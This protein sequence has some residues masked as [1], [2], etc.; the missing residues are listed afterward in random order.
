MADIKVLYINSDGKRNE[1]SESAD[2]VKFASYKTA[3]YELTDSKLGNLVDGSDA[4]DEH[5]HDA[6]YYRENEHVSTSAGAGD[7]GKPVVLDAGG[8][9]DESLIDVSALTALIDHGGLLGLGD[10]DHTIYTKADG[11]RDFSGIVSYSSHP[12]FTLDTQIVDKKYVDDILVSSE[13]FY[14]SALDYILDN[15]LAPPTEVAGD[16]YVLSH[17]GGAP[18][19]NWDGASAGDIVEFNGSVWVATTPSTGTRIGVDDEANVA[20]YLY[21]GSSWSPK[22]EE[23]TTASTG[24]TKVGFDIRI[25][26]SAAGDGLGFAA[27]VLNVN[28]DNSSVEINADTLRVKA[29][30]INDT[31]IDFGTGVNQV[32]AGDIPLVDAGG[33]FATDDVEFALQKLASDI[34]SPGIFYTVGVGGV[35]KGDALYISSNDTVSK[36]STLTADEEVVG[37]ALTTEAASGTVK[38]LAN[39]TIVT[40]VLTGAVAGTEY[41]WNGTTFV[42]TLTGF[43]GNQNIWKVGVA[44]NATDLHVQIEHIT[45]KNA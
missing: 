37:L 13:W 26:S 41:Y 19:A 25:A 1:H 36:Y 43:T 18:H 32:S 44:K 29:D 31:H 28:V 7:S 20:F 27:G 35:A 30:G 38:S 45:K 10:D 23:S 14:K 11:T 5:I 24:L 33:Y 40:G 12:T 22:Y 3:N 16:V 39:D 34:T 6:R 15:T 2:S 42:T 17:D 21:G 9:L 4:A 8:K